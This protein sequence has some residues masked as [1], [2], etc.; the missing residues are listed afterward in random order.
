MNFNSFLQIKRINPVKRECIT[1]MDRVDKSS[2]YCEP[3]GMD[4]MWKS[5]ILLVC[6]TNN[7]RLVKVVLNNE[8]LATEFVIEDL[9]PCKYSSYDQEILLGKFEVESGKEL[10]LTFD[11]LPSS[12]VLLTKD[13][14]HYLKLILSPIIWIDPPID[15]IEF[16]DLKTIKP[17]TLVPRNLDCEGSTRIFIECTFFLC[18]R[19]NGTCSKRNLKFVIPLKITNSLK[20]W[21]KN[22]VIRVTHEIS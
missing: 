3:S 18:N 10:L 16:S 21:N 19:N 7:H 11:F 1:V 14:I 12:T 17:L 15:V 6:D 2:K 22:Q 9:K 20:L 5:N 8:Y 13:S 4:I